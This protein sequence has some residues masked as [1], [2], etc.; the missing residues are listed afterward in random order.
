MFLAAFNHYRWKYLLI[1]QIV[2]GQF[3]T[4]QF[5]TVTTVETKYFD[6]AI[7]GDSVKS[8]TRFPLKSFTVAGCLIT[9]GIIANRSD[10][11]LDLDE[12]FKRKIWTDN[13]HPLTNADTYLQFAPV[14]MVY[15]LSAVGLKAKDNLLDLSMIYLLSNLIMN[16]AVTI[17][18]ELAHERRPDGSDY[19]S[20]PLG[21]Y[22]RSFCVCG[23]PI[24]GI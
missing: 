4:A 1:F 19:L 5:T 20:F 18:K 22:G 24:P 11:T 8:K 7:S 3:A 17:T 14:V 21:P 13:P 9:Y 15:G 6:T 2:T 12:N 23:I 16:S 10:I